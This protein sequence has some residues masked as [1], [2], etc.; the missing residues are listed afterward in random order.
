VP[1][2]LAEYGHHNAINFGIALFMLGRKEGNMIGLH[3]PPAVSARGGLFFG[4]LE[5]W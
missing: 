4:K 2:Q 5:P 1:I 3:Q